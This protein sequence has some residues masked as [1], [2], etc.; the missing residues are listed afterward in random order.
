[1]ILADALYY[2]TK[3]FKPQWTLNVATLTGAMDVALGSAFTGVFTNS[4]ELYSALDQSGRATGD[5]F[6]QMPLS[7]VYK[8]QIKSHTADLKNVGGRSAG[9]CTAAIFL[10]EFLH[11][12]TQPWAHLDIAG[13]MHHDGGS[14]GYHLKGMSGRPVRSLIKALEEFHRK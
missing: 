8:K 2:A 5:P 10:K 7:D 6:W 11:D 13:V 9:S 14:D 4:S 1:M 3:T 12:Q